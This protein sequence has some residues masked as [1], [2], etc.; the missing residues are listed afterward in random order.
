MSERV[1][2]IQFLHFRG[3]PDYEC[4]LNGKSI[5]ILGGN[6]KGK[7]AIVDGLEFLFGA[8]ISRFHG[9]G[10]GPIDADVAMRNVYTMGEPSV[11]ITFTPTNETVSRSLG[12]TSQLTSTRPLVRAYLERHPAVGAFVLRRSQILE[13]I[14]DQDAKRYQKYIRLLGLDWVDLTQRNFIEA[15]QTFDTQVS[16][17]RTSLQSALHLFRDAATSWIP[18]DSSSLFLKCAELANHFAEMTPT[19]WE[20]LDED[21]KRNGQS[22]RE[23]RSVP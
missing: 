11:A 4:H 6:G 3:L 18:T 1:R 17:L 15:E 13:F 7:S 20:Q 21:S 22:K 14:Q 23:R 12:Q 8:R 16:A 10:S 19:A 5:L 9:E 2:K